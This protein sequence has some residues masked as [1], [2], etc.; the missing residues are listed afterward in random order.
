[1]NACFVEVTVLRGDDASDTVPV[2]VALIESMWPSRPDAS[3]RA[4]QPHTTLRM[5]SGERIPIAETIQEVRGR[6]RDAVNSGVPL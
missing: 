3:V 2:A 6:I 4:A 5:A 1:M